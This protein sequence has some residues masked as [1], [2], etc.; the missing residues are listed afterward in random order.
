MT[1]PDPSASKVPL[2]M[3]VKEKQAHAPHI[4]RNTLWCQW[5]LGHYPD[6]A[7]VKLAAAFTLGHSLDL[8]PLLV[9]PA[10]TPQGRLMDCVVC[11]VKE[12]TCC[13]T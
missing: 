11:V 9:F 4:R 3:S 2:P 8:V 10:W 6:A 7:G 13:Q 5:C 1:L 12:N